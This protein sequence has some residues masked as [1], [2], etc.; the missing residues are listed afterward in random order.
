MASIESRTQ[1]RVISGFTGLSMK[2]QV[3]LR[4]TLEVIFQQPIGEHVFHLKPLSFPVMIVHRS[5]RAR[6]KRSHA[7]STNPEVERT[8]VL[9]K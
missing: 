2:A 1:G 7:L 4:V 3:R 6:A 5:N 9:A 8:L